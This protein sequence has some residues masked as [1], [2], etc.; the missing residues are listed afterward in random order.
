MYRQ[1]YAEVNL[2]NLTHN[3]QTLV[4]RYPDYTYFFGVVK[5]GCYGHNGSESIQAVLDGG[6]NYLAV[7]TLEEALTVRKSFR[8]VPILCFGIVKPEELSICV[9][10]NVTVTVSSLLWLRQIAK[11][12]P[13]LKAHIKV[14][15][16]MNRLGIAKREEFTEAVALAK[17]L[18]IT[19]EGV[20]THIYNA[21]SRED[22]LRQFA[23]FEE[24][25]SGVNLSDFSIV[26]VGASEATE[27]FPKRPYANGCRLGIAMYGLVDYKNIDLRPTFRLF[28]EVIQMNAV[29]EGVVGYNGAY[30][31]Q[32]N[33]RIA[34]VP[35][36]YADGII[37]KNSGRNVYIHDNPY[38]IVGNVCMDMLFV[39]VDET[40]QVGDK[41]AVIRDIEHI[42]QI[43]KHLDTITYE[44]ICSIG[45]RVP[46]IYVK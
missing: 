22:T 14:N 46:R 12:L 39:K 32:G 33:E 5:A 4:K 20:Y 35:I 16:G 38:P 7:A 3:V 25:T 29:S 27:Y 45:S 10:N 43:A 11:A 40:V 9:E 2:S 26:H 28:S 44:V 23:V 8:D 30:K 36:G 19:L 31:V 21:T 24:I 41:V 42:K 34:V 1:N 6:C 37:R 15:S 17:A 13:G 18:G